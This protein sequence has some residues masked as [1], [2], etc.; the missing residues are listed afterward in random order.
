M[1]EAT[2]LDP[3]TIKHGLRGHDCDEGGETVKL[4]VMCPPPLVPGRPEPALTLSFIIK[5]NVQIL[6]T[7]ECGEGVCL[8]R[9]TLEDDSAGDE[10]DGRRL[11]TTS[12]SRAWRY[13]SALGG[14]VGEQELVSWEPGDT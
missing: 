13:A 1:N 6:H 4:D 14:F 8:P 11:G 5:R 12:A 9:L 2:I 7:L 3:G 10:L